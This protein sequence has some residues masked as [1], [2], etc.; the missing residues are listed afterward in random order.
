MS[1]NTQASES[2]DS[3]NKTRKGKKKSAKKKKKTTPKA[4]ATVQPITKFFLPQ[5]ASTETTSVDTESCK[6]VLDELIQ[7]N[8]DLEAIH[9]QD[10]WAYCKFLADTDSRTTHPLSPD[11]PSGV[12]RVVKSTHAIWSL[13]RRCPASQLD[14]FRTLIRHARFAVTVRVSDQPIAP[15]DLA[16]TDKSSLITQKD[17]LVRSVIF[18]RTLEEAN[19]CDKCIQNGDLGP[20]DQWQQANPTLDLVFPP[21]DGSDTEPDA[22]KSPLANVEVEAKKDPPLPRGPANRLFLIEE[23]LLPLVRAIHC[24][25]HIEQIVRNMIQHHKLTTFTTHNFPPLAEL[26]QAHNTQRFIVIAFCEQ[27]TIQR[28]IK[29]V[30]AEN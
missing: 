3:T 25:F 30:T 19:L 23:A 2:V 18:T 1:T 4:S 28:R 16:Q 7:V 20:L 11:A 10:W 9:P 8:R 12:G 22:P 14:D 13:L 6:Q 17:Q 27:E 29:R 24:I 26:L 5:N 21:H 15:D